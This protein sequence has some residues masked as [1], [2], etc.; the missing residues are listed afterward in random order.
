MAKQIGEMWMG[1]EAG[2]HTNHKENRSVRIAISDLKPGSGHVQKAFT[3]SGGGDSS[4]LSPGDIPAGIYIEC[5]GSDSNGWGWAVVHPY[6]GVDIL[7]AT[8]FDENF[9]PSTLVF[10]LGLY[11]HCNNP[12]AGGG[13]VRV[14]VFAAE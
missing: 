4:T 13:N 1:H 7:S 3:N 12:G 5:E 6:G 14:K 8:D 2:D 10:T 11:L 9:R